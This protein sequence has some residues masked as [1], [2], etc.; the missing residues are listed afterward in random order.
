VAILSQS[1][2]RGNRWDPD[3]S[4]ATGRVEVDGMMER[5]KS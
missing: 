4:F 1:G 3:E 2:R 5:L